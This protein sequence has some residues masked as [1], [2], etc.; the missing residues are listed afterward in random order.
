MPN[1]AEVIVDQL[2]GI[3][4]V[5]EKDAEWARMNVDATLRK[6]RTE[7]NARARDRK[8]STRKRGITLLRPGH[9]EYEGVQALR[10]ESVERRG[11]LMSIE[12]LEVALARAERRRALARE[13]AVEA[14]ARP[15]GRVNSD[16]RRDVE[17]FEAILEEG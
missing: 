3:G 15:H 4:Y 10:R 12:E 16:W 2:V 11:F 7:Q 1:L 6:V 17:D 13:I 8:T 5:A 14:L 9:P